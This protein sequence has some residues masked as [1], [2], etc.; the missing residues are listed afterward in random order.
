MVQR[1]VSTIENDTKDVSITDEKL[2]GLCQNELHKCLDEVRRGA[3]PLRAGEHS[4]DV[5]L[6][7][8]NNSK[9]L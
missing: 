8:R 6:L 2:D 5:E 1:F 4:L 3:N 7:S 9:S